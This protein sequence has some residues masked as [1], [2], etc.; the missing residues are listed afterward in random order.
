MT[1]TYARIT[2]PSEEDI[3]LADVLGRQLSQYPTQEPTLRLRLEG[4]KEDME[5]P[6]SAF[7][8][9]KQILLEMS[10]GNAVTLFPVESEL[11]TQ[12]AADLLNVSR[13]YLVELLDKGLIPFRKVGTHR[14]LMAADVIAYQRKMQRER[15]E[16]VERLIALDQELGLE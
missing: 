1:F 6:V 7:L 4:Q 11:T 10:K 2:I 12:Q 8:L 9:F 5:I 15:R 3:H 13:P 16:A 14:R